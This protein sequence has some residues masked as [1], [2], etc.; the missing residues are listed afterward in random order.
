MPRKPLK[1]SKSTKS[2]K[3]K[4]WE[5]CKRITRLR[6][7]R[8]DGMW[9]CYTCDRLIDEP[10]KAHTG[11]FIPSGN[12]GGFLRYNLDNL[13][14]QDYFCNV[15]LGGNGAEYYKRMVEE[16]GQKS[17][18][19]IFRDKNKLIKLDCVYLQNLVDEYG[20]IIT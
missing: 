7:V 17:V 9:N 15:N 5:E 11:H 6:Y 18:D 3:A 4:V 8:P 2:L 14:I 12:C 10:A 20:S 19:Q 1:T 16:V 13:R